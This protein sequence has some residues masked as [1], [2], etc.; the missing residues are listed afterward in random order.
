MFTDEKPE[1]FKSIGLFIDD[2]DDRCSIFFMWRPCR[3]YISAYVLEAYLFRPNDNKMLN[4]L[5]VVPSAHRVL[6]RQV[7]FWIKNAYQRWKSL[8]YRKNIK[9]SK[10]HDRC[11][12]PLFFTFRETNTKI[13]TKTCGRSDE[14]QGKQDWKNLVRLNTL[15]LM[16][17]KTET[18]GRVTWRSNERSKKKKHSDV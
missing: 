15:T 13:I 7:L 16:T 3:N 4:I 1:H 5:L 6:I 17:G 9:N 10:T 2:Y 12:Y 8:F 18:L 14:R 11:F